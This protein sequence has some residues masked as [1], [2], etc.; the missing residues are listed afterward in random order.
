MFEK[1]KKQLSFLLSL[2][3][4][5][6]CISMPLS[7]AVHADGEIIINS[8]EDFAAFVS[9][10][11][12]ADAR[13][14]ADIDL[15][16][17]TTAFEDGYSG[18]LDGGGFSITYTKTNPTGNFHS[19]IKTLNEGGCIK[20]LTIKGSMTFSAA[21]T[22]N[23]PFVYEN[24][25]TIENCTNEMTITYS[26]T[27][28]CQYCAGIT[29]KNYGIVK[30]C[31]NKAD[32]SV[33]NYA[34]GIVAQ[35]YCGQVTG[36]TNSGK[37][38]VSNVAGYA[39]GIIAAICSD[40]DTY[41][42]L[43]ENCVN[44]GDVNGG[45]G[46]YGCAGGIVG[47]INIPTSASTYSS[48]PE[49]TIKGCSSSGTLS[50]GTTDEF[51]GKNNNSDNSTLTIEAGAP[52]HQHTYDDGVVTTE[53]T[54]G[55]A[56]VKTFTCS[57]CDENT[58]GH[59]YTEPVP[60]TGNHTPGEWTAETIEGEE[61]LVKRCTVCQALLAKKSAAAA[62]TL[63]NA[64][65]SLEDGFFRLKPVYGE[66][67]N[68]CTMLSDKLESLGYEGI[69]VSLSSAEN[70]ADSVSTIADDGTI[71]YFYADPN[72]WRAMYFSSIPVVFTLTLE[73]ADATYEKNAVIY[74]DADKAAQA[75]ETQVA[76]KVTD[77]TIKGEN[78]SLDS[79][80]G[81]LV[82]YKAVN[83]E[84]G[85]K[86]LWSLITWESSDEQVISIDDSAQA[87]ADTL[88]EPYKGVVNRSLEDKEVT[89]TATF[90]F[91]KTSYDEAPITVTKTF[92]VTVKG[93]GD[94]ILAEMQRQLD[95]NY[96]VDKLK[97]IGTKEVI[98]PEAVTNDVQ[99]LIPRTSGI[100]NYNDYTFTVE[101]GSPA[102]QVNVARL[103]ITRPLP[104][105]NPAD[106]VL[107]VTMTNKNHS[108]FSVSKELELTVSPITQAEIDEHLALMEQVKASLFEGI[109]NGANESA[110]KV[111][112]NL[113]SFIEA[114]PDG[115]GGIIWIRNV[116]DVTDAGI[117]AVSIDPSHPSEQWDR[118][119][120][121]DPKVI[122]H[123]NLLVTPAKENT[124][125]TITVC[126]SDEQFA[127]YAELYPENA[128]FA[129][130]SRQTVTVELTVPG[131]DPAPDN[132]DEPDE[133]DNPENPDEN[134]CPL[135]HKTHEG[136]FGRI[137]AF[138]HNVIYWIIDFFGKIYNFITK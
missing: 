107:T 65:Q 86:I 129:A 13:L 105:E 64:I 16:E 73:D 53:P 24:H 51:V 77:D 82:L 103:N 23:A 17:W 72:V 112:S 25:G 84:D 38:S 48:K 91:Q 29:A 59:S 96:T 49:I 136:F 43:I 76:S 109:N 11:A 28:N 108:G 138:F 97:Y 71:T 135:C 50:A 94:D 6:A 47:Q 20:N 124:D 55:K 14:N 40:T 33:R 74:W 90:S 128:D 130:L 122:T 137:I 2:I 88:F 56:G 133:P 62:A 118:F 1:T 9:G 69:S 100:D 95:E 125:V 106:V 57:G 66:D 30:N 19:L 4:T 36:C 83:D 58:E 22:F 117:T 92:N 81:D 113:S 121:S 42:N 32:I 10:S 78:E 110:D 34:G 46:E 21:R 31:I 3:L 70:P 15:G 26:G 102:A 123:E 126:L 119:R 132:P 134:L 127:R 7:A 5:F 52:A 35:N 85:N 37:I 87:S 93:M 44:T 114:V 61:L 45:S 98:D 79:V 89:L 104:G 39:G 54:C 60:A 68:V 67:T 8:A 63:E 111:T 18:T 120:S 115:K 80:T 75:V 99:L 101:S 12:E 41:T 27:K 116:K 131:T